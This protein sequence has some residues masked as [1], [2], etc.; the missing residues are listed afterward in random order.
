MGLMTGLAIGGALAG[1]LLAGKKMKGQQQAQT[2]P[3][4]PGPTENGTPA[5]MPQPP[6]VNPGGDLAQ[7]NAAGAKQRK[8]AALG[9]LMTRPLPKAGAMVPK[10]RPKTLTGY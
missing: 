9:G 4:A 1:G 6:A 5:D 10:T 8:R 7:A 3:M 2:P